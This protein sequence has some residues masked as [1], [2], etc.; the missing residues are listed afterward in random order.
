[1]KQGKKLTREQKEKLFKRGYKPDDWMFVG[2]LLD[3]KGRPTSYWKFI[4]KTS[5]RTMTMDRF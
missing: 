5:N 4:H 1:M 3:D 2:D